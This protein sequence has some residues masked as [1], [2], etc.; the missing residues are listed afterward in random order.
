VVGDR[1]PAK[2]SLTVQGQGKAGLQERDFSPLSED[3]YNLC[4]RQSVPSM[5]VRGMGGALGTPGAPRQHL[6]AVCAPLSS[7]LST[8]HGKTK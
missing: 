3:M 7:C 1:A 5:G 4:T 2:G 8:F 6:M